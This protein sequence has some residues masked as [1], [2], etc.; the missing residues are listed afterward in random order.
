[1]MHNL[2]R[3]GLE[4]EFQIINNLILSKSYDKLRFYPKTWKENRL[5]LTLNPIKIHQQY[6]KIHS[7]HT[8]STELNRMKKLKQLQIIHTRSNQAHSL[9]M[10]MQKNENPTYEK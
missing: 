4:P 8:T 2:Q 1:M 10:K 5:K 6:R 3:V 9:H 7:F